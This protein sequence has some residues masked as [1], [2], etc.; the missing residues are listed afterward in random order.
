MKASEML[1]FLCYVFYY[2]AG[3]VFTV[4]MLL[5]YSKFKDKVS[6][7]KLAKQCW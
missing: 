6:H 4:I 3:H 2:A 5:L 1:F 7:I